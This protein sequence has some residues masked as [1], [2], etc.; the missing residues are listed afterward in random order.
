VP[1]DT[2]GKFQGHAYILYGHTRRELLSDGLMLIGDAA[3]LAYPQSGEGIRTA[4]ESG[5]PAAEAIVSAKGD[6]CRSK[7]APYAQQLID[8]L[9]S[10]RP[11]ITP[12]VLR[13]HLSECSQALIVLAARCPGPLVSS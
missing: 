9:G 11:L 13:P 6:F 12:K 4:V 3:G 1:Q 5:L 7:L 2:P 8:R 10:P